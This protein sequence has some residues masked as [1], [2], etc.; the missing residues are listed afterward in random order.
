MTP[1][2]RADRINYHNCTHDFRYENLPSSIV[3]SFLSDPQQKFKRRKTA[4]APLKQYGFDHIRK[5]HDAILYG[6]NRASKRL[7]IVYGQDMKK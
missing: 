7:P 1:E 6:A 3:K 2:E 4:N 5:Y